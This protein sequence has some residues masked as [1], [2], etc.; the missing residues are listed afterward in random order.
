MGLDDAYYFSTHGCNLVFFFVAG[1]FVDAPFVAAVSFRAL[2]SKNPAM[3]VVSSRYLLGNG[4][5]DLA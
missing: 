5:P 3:I 1:A 4:I 2:M